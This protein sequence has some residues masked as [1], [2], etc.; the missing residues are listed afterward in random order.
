LRRAVLEAQTG[1]AQ[2]WLTRAHGWLIGGGRLR[3]NSQTPGARVFAMTAQ[4]ALL[5]TIAQEYGPLGV[6]PANWTTW[7]QTPQRLPRTPW[8]DE[9]CA[10]Y[11]W[12]R[13][14]AA[15]E[16]DATR[17]LETE[18]F[19]ECYFLLRD[20]A[21]GHERASVAQPDPSTLDQALAIIDAELD[22]P[23]SVSALARRVGAS[24]STLRR[25]FRRELGCAPKAYWRAR[26][27]DEALVLL[28]SDRFTV[29]EVAQA[30]GY[31]SPA[32]FAQA[33]ATR[34]GR[35]PTAWRSD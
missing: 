22:A 29:T 33:F 19:K 28:E 8:L 31:A 3:I 35:P 6:E 18:I 30:V 32:A 23:L 20:R 34:F 11:H 27:L 17:F 24:E 7:L 12:E 4:P 15:S 13:Q 21:D 14:L 10:R 25:L 5:D 26:R 1:G 2:A 9:I 16:N